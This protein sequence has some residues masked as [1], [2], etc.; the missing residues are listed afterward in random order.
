[1]CKHPYI[2]EINGQYVAL[3]CGKCIDCYKNYSYDWR[4]R[5][6]QEVI[7]CPNYWWVTLTYNDRNLPTCNVDGHEE[8]CVI[9]SEVQNFLK[10]LRQRLGFPELRYFAVGEYGKHNR[11]HYHL[12]IFTHAWKNVHQA[13]IDIAWSWCVRGD[14]NGF[15]YV[16]RGEIGK[17]NYVT[18]YV[19][20]LDLRHHNAK[21]FRL[22]SKSL[23]LSFLS[24]AMI[25]YY[26]QSKI[27]QV[28][29]G[30]RTFRLPRYYIRKLDEMFDNVYHAGLRWS[31]VSITRFI[32]S[33]DSPLWYHQYF[34]DNVEEIKD[35]FIENE[36]QSP[37]FVK[38][39]N[40]DVN[41]V[42]D[43]FLENCEVTRN[44]IWQG[45]ES[46]GKLSIKSD[47]DYFDKPI[48]QDIYLGREG[49]I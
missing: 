34:L 36:L 47:F 41:M 18:K 38:F 40:P 32:P 14:S 25:E 4:F 13:Y 12:L 7:R 48:G 17:I 35:D 5:L 21:P 10:R 44:D 37:Y 45:Q 30:N 15:V 43:W 23:G 33:Y 16:K 24:P 39:L 31:E 27:R 46:L 3:P 2:K 49:I 8:S 19:N 42:F 20:K 22:M 26:R 9:K 29:D 1:M 11:A 6:R 28:Y